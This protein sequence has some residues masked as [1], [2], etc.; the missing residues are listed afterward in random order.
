MDMRFY[1][2]GEG[3]V[4]RFLWQ[5]FRESAERAVAQDG[6]D[7]MKERLA[8]FD[9]AGR[10]RIP[11]PTPWERRMRKLYFAAADGG[12]AV[13]FT[14]ELQETLVRAFRQMR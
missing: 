9:A 12:E 14:R 7:K 4:Y 10:F 8:E 11:F 2:D 6:R 3:R 13:Y 5:Q 1:A